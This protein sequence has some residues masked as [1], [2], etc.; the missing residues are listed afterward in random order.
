MNLTALLDVTAQRVST[1]LDRSVSDDGGDAAFA[2]VMS[3]YGPD[4]GGK[5]TTEAADAAAPP[6]NAPAEAGAPAPNA[7]TAS[8]EPQDVESAGAQTGDGLPPVGHP[9]PLDPTLADLD[10]T[11][12]AHPAAKPVDDAASD[13]D[14]GSDP[15]AAAVLAALVAPAAAPVAARP[16]APVAPTPLPVVADTPTPAA[17]IV[18]KPTSAAN[19]AP[20][21]ANVPA[22]SDDTDA[23]PLDPTAFERIR[24][25]LDRLQRNAE[26]APTNEP[27]RAAAPLGTPT[28]VSAATAPL[29]GSVVQ[30][31]RTLNRGRDDSAPPL[32][33]LRGRDPRANADAAVAAPKPIATQLAAAVDAIARKE[34][35][36][37]SDT[38]DAPTRVDSTQTRLVGAD[39]LRDTP[40]TRL[41]DVAQQHAQR[42][43]TEL[44][45]RVLVMRNQRLDGAT[46]S[47]E[48]RELGRIDIQVRM[49]AD[50]MH[51]A[52]T[53]QHA[54]VRD[55]LEGQ[56]PRLRSMLEEAG[57]SLGAVDVAHAGARNATG[58]D[59]GTA[60]SYDPRPTTPADTETVDPTTAWRPRA[61]TS[62]IDLH[63]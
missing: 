15:T 35:T 43:A 19:D 62:L 44:A 52:F 1:P 54:A 23:T 18:A 9:L 3:Q 5:P 42:F 37:E 39:T 46:V 31:L 24:A 30:T 47:L 6:T 10:A 11:L 57:L 55:T 26:S 4:G 33:A 20:N 58:G 16:P 29:N 56:L 7:Q 48:P 17:P 59:G 40:S 49:Q 32:T 53:A 38:A 13:A 50:T 21:M 41:G 22:P 8:L 14:S 63:A 34:P 45:D 61:S 12:A 28:T 36:V 60:R 2:D 27:R 25:Q 51:I